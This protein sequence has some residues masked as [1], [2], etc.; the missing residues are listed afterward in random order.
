[1]EFI[2]WRVAGSFESWWPLCAC[3]DRQGR[4]LI[5]LSLKLKEELI[6]VVWWECASL[7]SSLVDEVAEESMGPLWG[8]HFIQNMS[9]SL[10]TQKGKE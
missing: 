9:F 6:G 4:W 2:L 8:S 1:M 3:M 7:F 5:S 10:G